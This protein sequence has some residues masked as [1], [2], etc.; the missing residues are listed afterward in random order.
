M[1]MIRRLL[2]AIVV[3][4]LGVL[5]TLANLRDGL[6]FSFPLLLGL[7]LLADGGLRLAMQRQER[8]RPAA[9]DATES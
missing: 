3:L 8:D 6:A 1:P 7:L 2:L 5:V 4:A 9:P